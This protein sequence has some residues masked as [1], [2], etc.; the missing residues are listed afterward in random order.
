MNGVAVALDA[1]PF[2]ENG[3]TYVPLRFVSENL[4]MDVQWDAARAHVTLTSRVQLTLGMD[5]KEVRSTFGAPARTAVSEKGYTWWV[6][7]DVS[8]YKLLGVSEER[9]RT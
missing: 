3:S 2:V 8:D 1:P 7:D 6:Y 5:A 4:L 9:N